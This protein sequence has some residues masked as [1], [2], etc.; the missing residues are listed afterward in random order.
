MEAMRAAPSALSHA[1]S[2][3]GDRWSLVLVDALMDGP[4]RFAELQEAV[5]GISSN[6]LASRLRHLEA[7]G[8]VVASPYSARPRRYSYDLT[9]AGRDLAGAVRTL[10]QWGAD[11]RAGG[12]SHAGTGGHAGTGDGDVGTPVHQPCGT[13]MV[14]VWWCPTCEVPG[15]GDRADAVWV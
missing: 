3:V 15:E 13:S 9:D 11:R 1:L 8:V 4:R 2:R 10:S 5:P 14:A 6:I 12:G 7:E